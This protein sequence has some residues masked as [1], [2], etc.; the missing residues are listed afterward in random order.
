M[1]HSYAR[2]LEFVALVRLARRKWRTD[3]DDLKQYHGLLETIV[4]RYV[5]LMR[6]VLRHCAANHHPMIELSGKVLFVCLFV[7]SVFPETS[8]DM[9]FPHTRAEI[10]TAPPFLPLEEDPF[11]S[12]LEHH[13]TDGFA[14]SDF[15]VPESPTANPSRKGI[16]P[17]DETRRFPEFMYPLQ[18]QRP[19]RETLD[20]FRQWICQRMAHA[21]LRVWSDRFGV[22]ETITDDQL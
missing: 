9:D 10:D 14:A 7:I 21:S 15:Y 2:F 19:R 4:D 3:Y 22:D 5:V 13:R 20:T 17:W 6:S 12:D 16:V 18:Q 1:L 11:N 8:F